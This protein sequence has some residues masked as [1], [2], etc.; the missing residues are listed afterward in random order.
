MDL[1]D[2]TKDLTS[3]TNYRITQ[4]MEEMMRTNPNYRNLDGANREVIM[5]LIKKYKEK[6]RHGLKPSRLT[7]RDDKYNLYENRIKLGLTH[8]DLEQINNLLDSFKE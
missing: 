7:V 8:Y 3:Q 1:Q 4:R 5:D 6:I 2:I